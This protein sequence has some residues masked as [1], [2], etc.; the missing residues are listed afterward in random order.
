MFTLGKLLFSHNQL[1]FLKVK[2]AKVLTD[3][4]QKKIAQV[5][6]EGSFSTCRGKGIGCVTFPTM[7]SNIPTKTTILPL[8]Y[9]CTIKPDNTKKC[10]LPGCNISNPNESWSVLTGCFQSI[11]CKC[12]DE[13]TS[14]PLCKDFLQKK[15]QEL[16]EIAK[17]ATLHPHATDTDDH[18]ESTTASMTDS[19]GDEEN[20]RCERNGDGRI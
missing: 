4:V 17:E 16:G 8:R 19:T 13:F 15:V 20:H 2:C 7:C 1:Q 5:P 11:H 6:R 9:H 10:D 3:M 12:L 18:N 14:C